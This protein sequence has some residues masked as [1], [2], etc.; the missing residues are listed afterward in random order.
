MAELR[1]QANAHSDIQRFGFN[2]KNGRKTA[3]QDEV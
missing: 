2:P 1:S 3:V